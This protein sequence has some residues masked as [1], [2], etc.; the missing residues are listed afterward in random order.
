MAV[1][2]HIGTAVPQYVHLQE[3]IRLYMQRQ[4]QLDSKAAKLTNII[5]KRSGIAQRHSVLSDFS[6]TE[7]S[8][9]FLPDADIGVSERMKKYAGEALQ[10]SQKAIKNTLSDVELDGVT[11]LITVSCTGMSAPGLDLQLV[12][13]LSLKTSI[14]RTS[15]NF[16]GC[17][18]AIHALKLADAFCRSNE[19]TKV[20]IVCTELC[21]LHFQNTSNVEDILS[22][23]LFADG[24]AACVVTNED[25]AGLNISNFHS[26]IAFEGYDDM[27]WEISNHGFLMNLS[28]YV[29]K[30]L[31]KDMK[32]LLDSNL[33]KT[34]YKKEDIKHWAIHPGG[35]NILEA[36]Q[37][38]LEISSDDLA[39]SYKTLNDNGNMSSPTVLFVLKDIMDKAKSNE[40]I[41]MAAFGPGLTIESALLS[42]N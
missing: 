19:K 36:T 24:S 41:F 40:P 4:L 31:E 30:L 29:P 13:A 9:F 17:Y 32:S 8:P 16:M 25:V 2:S 38:A 35:K 1:I 18:A 26:E 23:C 39:S 28:T 5:Y 42:K 15:V 21:T 12:K 14:V 20:L 22:A 11:H 3:D 33:E 37:K 27:A 34:N 10:L 6:S 7:E